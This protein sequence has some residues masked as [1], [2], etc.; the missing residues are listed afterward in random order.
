MALVFQVELWYSCLA[1]ISFQGSDAAFISLSP[2]LLQNSSKAQHLPIQILLYVLLTE[3]SPETPV[4][5]LCLLKLLISGEQIESGSHIPFYSS[6]N[7]MAR[8][9]FLTLY[10]HAGF[11]FKLHYLDTLQSYNKVRNVINM[12][13]HPIKPYTFRSCSWFVFQQERVE[14][15]MLN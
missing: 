15:L 1:S 8:R 10:P 2:L 3:S 13:C 7:L 9:G 4:R 11:F 5:C 12:K 6:S 14:E